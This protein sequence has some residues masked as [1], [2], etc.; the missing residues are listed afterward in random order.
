MKNCYFLLFLFCGLAFS[1]QSHAQWFD[2]SINSMTTRVELEFWLESKSGSAQ[3][4]AKRLSEKVFNEFSRI[5]ERMSR[6]REDSELSEV[7]R[8]AASKDV[9]VSSELLIV[10]KKSQQVSRLSGGAFDMTFSSVGYLYDLRA[11]VQPDQKAIR[12][13]LPAIN[14]QNVLLN[15]TART[16]GFKEKGVLIDLGGIAKGYAVDQGVAILKK[17]GIK[18]ARLSA[19]GDMYLL[20][21]KRG[22]PWVVG[23]KDPRPA[24]NVIPPV[25][26][27]WKNAKQ[28]TASEFIV[29]LPLAEVAIST[30]GDYERFFIDEAGQRI[31]HI[32][33]PETGKPAKGI[34]S[35]SVIGPDTTTTDGLSTAIFVL[36]VKEGLAL[37]ERLAGIDAIIIDD[38]RKFHYSTD[39]MQP[40]KK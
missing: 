25:E 15:P 17:A 10:L 36:G 19:G 3:A 29:A 31:H 7:N 6:Y 16:V 13:S 37:V 14:Y 11:S 20:G 9:L 40:A 28:D 21:D 26:N 27:N 23:I 35:V 32:L 8:M 38:Q 18:H 1:I 39:L 33:S 4:R 5:D 12:E 2:F 34:Q 24:G 30:S 22:K